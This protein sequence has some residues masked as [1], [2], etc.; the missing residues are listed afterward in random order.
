[1]RLDNLFTVLIIFGWLR[2]GL[3]SRD[4]AS[5]TTG[6]FL[7]CSVIAILMAIASNAYFTQ[8]EYW[9]TKI[10]YTTGIGSYWRQVLIYFQSVSKSLLSFLVL[11]FLVNYFRPG[12]RYTSNQLS[13][14]KLLC[15]IIVTRFLLFPSFEERFFTAFYLVG[16]FVLLEALYIN[17]ID[18][19][20]RI[21][22]KSTV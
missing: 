15:L 3:K 8:D 14:L 1:M 2:Y 22:N 5:L 10:S 9:F 12:I 7:L 20:Q 13:F 16:L 6:Q 4:N 19:G 11:F 17:P 21:P 18:E